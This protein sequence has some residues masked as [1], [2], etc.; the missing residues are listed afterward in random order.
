VFNASPSLDQV[1]LQQSGDNETRRGPRGREGVLLLVAVLTS[2]SSFAGER[3]PWWYPYVTGAFAG[4]GIIVLVQA[5]V[6]PT[7]GD[8]VRHLARRR[9]LDRA[10]RELS[11][12]FHQLV[13]EFEGLVNS[14]SRDTFARYFWE[15]AAHDPGWRAQLPGLIPPWYFAE[16]FKVFHRSLERWDGT[17]EELTALAGAFTSVVTQYGQVYVRPTLEALRRLEGV[18]LPEQIRRK[19]NLLREEYA[20]FGRNYRAFGQSRWPSG[21]ERSP[22]ATSGS[23]PQS[24]WGVVEEFC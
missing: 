4:V 22:S 10:A 5:F 19:V 17:Y 23:I 14:E 11:T 13:R 24:L 18:Q 9:Y 1:S 2:V 15:L 7:A 12:G 20:A 16:F 21:T 8:A 3:A 6:W